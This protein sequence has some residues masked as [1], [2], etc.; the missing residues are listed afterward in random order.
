VSQNA[1]AHSGLGEPSFERFALKTPDELL[2]RRVIYPVYFE[3]HFTTVVFDTPTSKRSGRLT[4]LDPLEHFPDQV[5]TAFQLW[6]KY[7][8]FIGTST[9]HVHGGIQVENTTECGIFAL[10]NLNALLETDTFFSVSDWKQES[11]HRDVYS[12]ISAPKMY[13]ALLREHVI[14]YIVRVHLPVFLQSMF[15]LVR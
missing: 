14:Q 10:R 12:C 8:K 7:K 4:F 6:F 2:Y 5:T 13:A 1:H 11:K 15:L 9:V 3:N